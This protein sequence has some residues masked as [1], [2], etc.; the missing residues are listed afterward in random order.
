[1]DVGYA[2]H[3]AFSANERRASKGPR[4]HAS[5]L[6]WYPTSRCVLFHQVSKTF[7]IAS[8]SV[9]IRIY[10]LDLT[11]CLPDVHI[12]VASRA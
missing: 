11:L 5:N 4:I 3:T 2:V 10:G 6:G 9:R 1:M 12:Y 7:V 8:N